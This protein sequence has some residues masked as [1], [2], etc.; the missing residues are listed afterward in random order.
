MAKV[1]SPSSHLWCHAHQPSGCCTRYIQ[2][3]VSGI[4]RVS[5]PRPY[6]ARTLSSH[7]PAVLPIHLDDL[8][9]PSSMMMHP[10]LSRVRTIESHS[11]VRVVESVNGEAFL[12]RERLA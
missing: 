9:E 6:I 10:P 5:E 3:A 1:S 4:D 11:L 12:P 7:T 2:D 8:R